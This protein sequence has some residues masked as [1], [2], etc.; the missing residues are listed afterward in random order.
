MKLKIITLEVDFLKTN[1]TY[2]LFLI[3]LLPLNTL[4][5][6][7]YKL[8]IINTDSQKIFKK[9]EYKKQFITKEFLQK[10]V[11]NVYISLIDEGFIMASV[12]SLICDSLACKA[13]V[14]AGKKH[15]W[16]K[17]AYDKKD[18]GIVTKLGYNEHFFTNRPFKFAELS[19]LMEKI[20]VYYENNGYPFA[21]AKLDSL[22]VLENTIGAKLVIEKNEF[23]KLDSLVTEGEGKVSQKFLLRYLGIKNGMPYNEAAFRGVSK[24][25]KQLP[26]VTE[27]KSPVLRLTDKQNKLYLFLDKK[28][29]SQFD[30]IVGILPNDKGK[31]IFTGDVKIKLVNTIFKSGETFDINWRR[32]QSQTQDL[33]VHV[34]YP[35]IAGLPIG[36]DYDIKLYKKDTTFIDISN[37]L[38]LN[39][40][41]SGLNYFKV[42]YKQR[43]AN[44][45]STSY[46]ANIT[47][48][49]EYADIVTKAYGVGIFLEKFDYRFNPRKGF[50]LAAQI[51][52][53]NRQ[54]KK[55]P[56]IN[57]QAYAQVQL[58][59]S[60]YQ[61]DGD[62]A[63]Y[64]N[65]VK[66]HVLK[67][68]AQAGGLVGNSL[69]RNELFRIGGLR[70]LRGFDEESIYA[71]TYV[72]PTIEYRFL[73]EKNSNIFLFAEGAWYESNS[74]TGYI[75]DT[76][77][78]V[79]AGINFETKAG[80]FNLSY[81]LGKQ[82][83]NTFDLRTGKIHAG[84]T[85]LF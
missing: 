46:L 72:I 62:I 49:P 48:L 1:L 85:A 40:Y 38:G 77:V 45:I 36:V 53:G 73:F 27:S 39:Y 69:Y 42:F 81:G 8:N 10:E 64:I 51:S 75:T 6:R 83:G 56:K 54:I 67:L 2:F 35:Y 7:L 32:L 17:L 21:S 65:I 4:A 41:Y 82:M 25:I 57:D 22:T 71:S 30:G 14:F 80:I 33:K 66:N 70:T 9:I 16:V 44:L 50:H 12:D 63:G 58:K 43:N 78:S 18:Q 19:G 34:T 55:N 52:A 47:V 59:S 23:I 68:S 13:Y 15:K 31:T 5:Q 26:F 60:Q 28:N 29:A 20:V 24:K 79:G 3:L 61:V 11:N 76:P 84:L 74:T 37:A